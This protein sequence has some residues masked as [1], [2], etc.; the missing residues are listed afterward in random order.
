MQY[1]HGSTNG[2][3]HPYLRDDFWA[4]GKDGHFGWL[5]ETYANAPKV[6]ARLERIRKKA[7]GKKPILSEKKNAQ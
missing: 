4:K 2:M 5:W 7:K 3:R 1:S 6:L